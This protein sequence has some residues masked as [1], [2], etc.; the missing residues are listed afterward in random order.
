MFNACII[1]SLRPQLMAHCRVIHVRLN[2][3]IYYVCVQRAL[4]LEDMD[5]FV[6]YIVE[7]RPTTSD[8]GGEHTLATRLHRANQLM[9]RALANTDETDTVTSTQPTECRLSLTLTEH[10]TTCDY[11]RCRSSTQQHDHTASPS[12]LTCMCECVRLHVEVS[13]VQ[14][15]H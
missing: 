15:A 10:A 3:L 11:Y 7:Q 2:W 8:G 13:D 14:C 4:L 9:Q 1:D 6:T 12:L 5:D